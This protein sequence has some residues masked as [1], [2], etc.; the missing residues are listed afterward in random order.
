MNFN[1]QGHVGEI[2]QGG[3]V[4][5]EVVESPTKGVRMG[6]SASEDA[7]SANVRNDIGLV[8]SDIRVY[9]IYFRTLE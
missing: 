2:L 1:Q 3:E 9:V 7:P 6:T 4:G 8:I 5:E